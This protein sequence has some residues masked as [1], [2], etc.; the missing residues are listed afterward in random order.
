MTLPSPKGRWASEH[1]QQGSLSPEE[2][3][4]R[5][6]VE[7]LTDPDNKP[8]HKERPGACLPSYY[9]PQQDL[10][11]LRLVSLDW[12]VDTYYGGVTAKA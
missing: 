4:P 1:R 12:G 7:L 6:V 10:Y 9:A 11:V 5:E 8:L 2:S 3:S